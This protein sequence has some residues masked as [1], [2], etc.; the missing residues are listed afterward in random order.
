MIENNPKKTA[1]PRIFLVS[2][3][4]LDKK[5]YA[6]LMNE[7]KNYSDSKNVNKIKNIFKHPAIQLKK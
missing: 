4:S 1:H 2:E 5:L 7:I 3:K 6:S